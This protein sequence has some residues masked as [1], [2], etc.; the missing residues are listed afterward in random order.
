[1]GRKILEK[2]MGKGQEGE[3]N[4]THFYWKLEEARNER[5]NKEWNR[6]RFE[7]HPSFNAYFDLKASTN[8]KAFNKMMLFVYNTHN[9]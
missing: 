6:K 2:L 1:M 9:Q 5:W 4:E 3:C 8:F 7:M